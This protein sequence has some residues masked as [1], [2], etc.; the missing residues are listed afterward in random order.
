[1]NTT[2]KTVTQKIN[3]DFQSQW[4]YGS[5]SIEITKQDGTD[6]IYST[7]T[8]IPEGDSW[9]SQRLA[10]IS[11]YVRPSQPNPIFFNLPKTSWPGTYSSAFSQKEQ[12]MKEALDELS[13]QATEW[14]ERFVYTKT[15]E[16]R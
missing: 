2:Y 9:Q 3:V 16:C 5:R 15:P 14:V 4:N 7:I 10:E 12:V 1:M 11:V 6:P 8:L 13:D